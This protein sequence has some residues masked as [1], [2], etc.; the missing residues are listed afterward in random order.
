MK[1]IR[2][3]NKKKDK[4][5]QEF[6]VAKNYFENRITMCRDDWFSKGFVLLEFEQFCNY[7]GT[8]IK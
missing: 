3:R 4:Q 5:Y 7:I 6:M 1:T 2:W 8:Q